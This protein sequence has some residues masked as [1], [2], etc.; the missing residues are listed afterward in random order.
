MSLLVHESMSR[1]VHSVVI[2]GICLIIPVYASAQIDTGDVAGW[3]VA[4]ELGNVSQ[5]P[6]HIEFREADIKEALR[7]LAKIVN[8]NLVIPEGVEGVVNVTLDDIK[9]I[10]AINAITKANG[11]EY[12]VERGV[13]RIGESAQFTTSGEDLKTETFRLKYALAEPLAEKVTQLVTKRGSVLADSRTNSLVVRE[14]LANIDHVRRLVE[15]VDVRDAQVLIEARIVDATRD[16]SRNLGIQWG[17]TSTTV[18][19]ANVQGVSVVGTSD[20][21]RRLMVNLPAD[22]PSSGLGLLIGTIGAGSI[23]IDAAITAAERKGD[24]HVISEPSIV[25]SNGMAAHIRSGETI[26]VKTAGS[27]QIG[28]SSASGGSSSG[29]EQIRTGVELNVTPQI[30]QGEYVKLT[31]EAVTSA[32]DFNRVVDGIPAIVDNE[33]TT[34]VLVR[35]RETTIIGGLIRFRGEDIKRKVPFLGEI[36]L[37]GYLFQSRQRAKTNSDLLLFIR[38]VIVHDRIPS[39]LQDQLAHTDVVKADFTIEDEPHLPK[40]HG[41]KALRPSRRW[42]SKSQGGSKYDRP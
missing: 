36:P 37:F 19:G 32:A 14:T 39:S 11:L 10:D 20:A 15:N 1:W 27:V 29:L 9:I 35:D 3:Q 13:L 7:F 38:P 24:L 2:V 33:A 4:K 34:T 41:V 30:S 31:I 16:W 42:R 22:S 25:T 8:M 5:A 18:P 21:G 40:R 12:A 17:A 28:G 23:N 26:Y 6:Y